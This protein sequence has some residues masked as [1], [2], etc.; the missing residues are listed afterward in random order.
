MTSYSSEAY[1]LGRNGETASCSLGGNEMCH[2]HQ[3]ATEYVVFIG[4]QPGWTEQPKQGL[5][6]RR[7]EETG[8]LFDCVRSKWGP[9]HREGSSIPQKQRKHTCVGVP[10]VETPS[11]WS[12]GVWRTA[13]QRNRLVL[14][15]LQSKR[16]PVHPPSTALLQPPRATIHP[17]RPPPASTG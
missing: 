6:Y 12:R 8:P 4:S 9:V 17:P 7:T 15:R 2:V 1:R 10:M 14:E 5:A 16:G 3:E 13:K 11:C